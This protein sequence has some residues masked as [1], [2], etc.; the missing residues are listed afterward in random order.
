MQMVLSVHEKLRESKYVDNH[1]LND[2]IAELVHL[3]NEGFVRNGVK[4]TIS[5]WFRIRVCMIDWILY[6]LLFFIIFYRI[7]KLCKRDCE[8]RLCKSLRISQLSPSS[9]LM[10]H[11]SQIL[12]ALSVPIRVASAQIIWFIYLCQLIAVAIAMI[13]VCKWTFISCIDTSFRKI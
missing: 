6:H 7:A 1:L 11:T 12:A 10:P 13:D 8:F 2:V 9:Q 5:V 3:E 4:Y